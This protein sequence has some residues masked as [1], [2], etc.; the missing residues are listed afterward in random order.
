MTRPLTFAERLLVVS[1]AIVWIGT[2]IYSCTEHL[3][4]GNTINQ[5]EIRHERSANPR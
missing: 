1:Y 2:A 5:G 3:Y 4:S